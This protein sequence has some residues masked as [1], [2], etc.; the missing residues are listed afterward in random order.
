MIGSP[1]LS[2]ALTL[3]AIGFLTFDGAALAGIG[4][5]SGRTM[6]VAMGLVFFVSAGLVLLYWRW[7]RRRLLDIASERGALSEDVREMQRLLREK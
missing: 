1:V 6:L 4:L 2:R 5:M 7:H 3:V